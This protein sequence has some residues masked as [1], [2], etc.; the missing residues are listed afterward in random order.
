MLEGAQHL[1]LEG[2]KLKG[3]LRNKDGGWHN[4]EMDLD[5]WIGNSDGKPRYLSNPPP[6]FLSFSLQFPPLTMPPLT[7]NRPPNL[8][9]QKLHR[10]RHQHRPP[11]PL[12][13]A[14]A[15]RD[16]PPR[17]RLRGPRPAAHPRRAHREHGRELYDPRAGGDGAWRG[18]GE[19]REG[20][21]LEAGCVV[22]V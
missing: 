18:V 12:L 6:R 16:A 13:P 2:S 7:P 4:A 5:Q 1:R 20:S 9:R 3:V 21:S 14:R 11:A 10:K 17:R 19:G 22:E 15:R 8:V